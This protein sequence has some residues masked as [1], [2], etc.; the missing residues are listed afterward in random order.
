MAT[1]PKRK[2]GSND[3]GTGQSGSDVPARS[4]VRFD[5]QDPSSSVAASSFDG[6][7]LISE[8]DP[9]A[10][11]EPEPILHPPRLKGK[12]PA[13]D[14]TLPIAPQEST[15]YGNLFSSVGCS[16]P[17]KL[18]PLSGSPADFDPYAASFAGSRRNNRY[19]GGRITDLPTPYSGPPS[20]VPLSTFADSMDLEGSSPYA[21]SPAQGAPPPYDE[22]STTAATKKSLKAAGPPH[23][24]EAM[25]RIPWATGGSTVVPRANLGFRDVQGTLVSTV[26]N[27]PLYGPYDLASFFTRRF[28]HVKRLSLLISVL[29]DS[30]YSYEGSRQLA[31]TVRLLAAFGNHDYEFHIKVGCERSVPEPRRTIIEARAWAA[32]VE[33][34]PSQ[35]FWLLSI[36]DVAEN[37]GKG[38]KFVYNTL[39]PYGRLSNAPGLTMG[40]SNIRAGPSYEQLE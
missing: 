16:F 23:V 20:Q 38:P 7:L 11:Q 9:F 15:D 5:Y 35:G 33:W 14:T 12:G 22:T 34:V 4:R 36:E 30:A 18:S 1:S 32:F 25:I 39:L 26:M 40:R 37:W 6:Q 2:R 29:G 27:H 3:P 10:V 31:E 19:V 24:V 28:P 17:P 21:A 8:E 13:L